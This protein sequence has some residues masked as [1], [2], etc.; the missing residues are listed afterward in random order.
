MTATPQRNGEPLRGPT[1]A[2]YQHLLDEND[3][4]RLQ[5]AKLRSDLKRKQRTITWLIEIIN[6]DE[7][8]INNMAKGPAHTTGPTSG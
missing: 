3:A 5:L 2:E 8:R 6:K 4:L 1:S 7:E